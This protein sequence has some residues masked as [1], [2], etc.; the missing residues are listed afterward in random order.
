MRKLSTWLIVAL[1]GGAFLIGIAAASL[2][3]GGG[4]G[5]GS[6][7][8]PSTS[9]TAG[10]PSVSS[11]TTPPRVSATVRSSPTQKPHAVAVQKVAPAGGDPAVVRIVHTVVRSGPGQVPVPEANPLAGGTSTPASPPAPA[12]SPPAPPP[13]SRSEPSAPSEH[14]AAEQEQGARQAVATAAVNL[15]K[16]TAA[17]SSETSAVSKVIE[18][19]EHCLELV[20]TSGLPPGVG[21]TPCEPGS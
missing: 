6:S 18:E 7:S 21:S 1:T 17:E 15:L 5:H 11:S 14:S 10:T 20:A 12:P 13:A 8:T 3:A 9:A 16:S 2:L 4:G 19:L